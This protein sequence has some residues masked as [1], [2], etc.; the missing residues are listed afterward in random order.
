MD[1][2]LPV[3]GSIKARGGV[4]EVLK[5]AEELAIEAG[6]LKLE[7]DYSI[8]ADKKFKNFFSKYLILFTG[9][10]TFANRKINSDSME[11]QLKRKELKCILML[12]WIML[13]GSVFNMNASTFN[14]DGDVVIIHTDKPKSSSTTSNSK[15]RHAPMHRKTKMVRLEF[16]QDMNDVIILL[17]ESGQITETYN[18]GN[19][20]SGNEI[21]IS[22]SANSGE[23][24]IEIYSEGEIIKFFLF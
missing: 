3:A 5:H 11:R 10:P 8:L 4:Y 2:H 24:C 17:K 18:I 15:P 9:T 6:L 1:S 19:I 23:S 21:P 22:I 13:I 7:D 20:L 14:V 16:L 12:I